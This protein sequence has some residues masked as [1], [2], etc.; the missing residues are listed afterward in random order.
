[1][2]SMMWCSIA[3]ACIIMIDYYCN[4]QSC[5]GFFLEVGVFVLLFFVVFCYVTICVLLARFNV[6]LLFILPV[7][8]CM[9]SQMCRS[10]ACTQLLASCTWSMLSQVSLAT[11]NWFSRTVPSYLHSTHG[12]HRSEVILVG[13]SSVLGD[14]L[15]Q[16]AVDLTPACT[17]SYIQDESNR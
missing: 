8:I 3:I 11:C 10:Q 17:Y 13:L 6:Y 16:H 1:M 4:V 5:F 9:Q 7:G 2:L 14:I 15:L 12:E